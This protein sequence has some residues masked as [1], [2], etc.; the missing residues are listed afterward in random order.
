ML[1]LSCLTMKEIVL[2]LLL[3]IVSLYIIYKTYF[4][5][6]YNSANLVDNKEL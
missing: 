3:L 5:N 1:G 2:L 6:I 4:F